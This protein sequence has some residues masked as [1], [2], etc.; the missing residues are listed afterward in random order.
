MF[1]K[2]IKKMT[3]WD[4]ALVKIAVMAF[5]LAIVKWKPIMDWVN[6]TNVW[7]FI[8]VF[9]IAYVVVQARIWRK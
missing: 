4:I 9:V 8:A 5:V 3:M 6:T 7:W 1:E 2:Q